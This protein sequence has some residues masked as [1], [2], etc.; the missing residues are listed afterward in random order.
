MIIEAAPGLFRAIEV[1]YGAQASDLA[2]SRT[3]A[4]SDTNGRR[5]QG[6]W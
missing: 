5:R 3:L 4:R 2:D 6:L 1:R